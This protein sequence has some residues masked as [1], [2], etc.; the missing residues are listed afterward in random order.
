MPNGEKQKVVKKD[1][2]NT[3]E[4]ETDIANEIKIHENKLEEIR[5]N[6]KARQLHTCTETNCTPLLGYTKCTIT[7]I[8]IACHYYTIHDV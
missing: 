6:R 8:F 4:D 1:E 5:N 7:M 2:D 3:K